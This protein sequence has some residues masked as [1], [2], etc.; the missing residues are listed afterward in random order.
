MKK[1]N[2]TWAI[3]GRLLFVLFLVICSFAFAMFQ[4]GFVSWFIFYSLLPFAL[5]S[6]AFFFSP[7]S[8]IEVE[9]YIQTAQIRKGGKLIATVKLKR[10]S[11]FPMLYLVIKEVTQSAPLIKHASEK[12][13]TVK[14]VGFQRTIEWTYEIDHMPRGE[15]ALDGVEISVSDFFG[16][17]KKTHVLPLKQTVIVYPNVTEMIYMPIETRYDQGAAASPFTIVKDTTMATGVRDYQ[18][19]DR[20]S[21][22]HWKSFARTQT[23]RTKEFEDRQSQDLFLL[24]DR[25]PSGSFEEQIELTAS[26]LQAVVRNQASAAFLS[27]GAT[28]FY[29]P[30]VQS[31]EQLQRTMFHL[32]KVEADLA[33]PIEKLLP[34]DPGMSSATSILLITGELTPALI[35]TIPRAAKNLRQCTV[36]VVV[37]KGVK[38]SKQALTVHQL[39]RSRGMII[40]VLSQDHFA[41]AFTEVG[42]T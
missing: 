35:E 24:V 40:H 37:K 36:F 7:I 38:L 17:V 41:N 21:W 10:P 19:G 31:E 33:Q 30:A 39:A 4:G 13:K 23:L 5:Y 14:M 15:H 20:V 1:I 28:R 11:R 25:K 9:R 27:L 34:K 22:I 2:F 29:F 32:A 3:G 12:L 18:P 42:R 16:W 8:K 26:V 6:I